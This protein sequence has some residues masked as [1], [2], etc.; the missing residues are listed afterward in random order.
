M[1]ELPPRPTPPRSVRESAR[2]WLDWFGITRVVA[3]ALA[4]VVVVGG[5]WLLVRT[6]PPAVEATLP[7][8]SG[9]APSATLP[10]PTLPSAGTETSTFV[11]HVAGAV[12]A[13]GV[14][15]V[16]G[17]ARVVDAIEAAGGPTPQAELDSLNL[18]ASLADGQRIY[19]PVVGE[20]VVPVDDGSVGDDAS[21]GPIDLNT[22]TVV[23]LDQLPGV[24]PATASAIV[25]HRD[26]HGPF[27]TVDDLTDVRG[28]GPAKLDAIRG[29]VRV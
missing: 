29:L 1:S 3:T 21:R 10:V 7:A 27:A 28:I 23:E 13:P 15:D 19:V 9:S 6:P 16:R 22:A 11:V 14:Y 26:E 4:V 5:A 24:G 17:P 2:A 8:T 18:A 25:E 12:A 20:I